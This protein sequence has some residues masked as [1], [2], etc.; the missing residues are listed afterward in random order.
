MSSSR[1]SNSR[2]IEI[3][4][5]EIGIRGWARWF[6]RQLTS[7]RTALLL[8]L[9]L[10]IAAV[11]GSIYPQRSA[12]P[13]GVKL[14][15]ENNPDLAAVLDNFQIFDVYTSVWF[16]AIYILLFTSLVGCVVP[17]TKVHYAALRSQPPV[18][19]R[20]FARMP[21]HKI[22]KSRKANVVERAA[23]ILR[24]Q[25]YRVVTTRTA[26]SAERGY[27]RETGNLI[28]HFSLIGV[29]ISVGIG[30]GLSYSGQRVLVEGDTF[31]NNL[32]GYDSIS[33]GTFFDESRLTPFS[34]RLDKF[35]VIFDIRN[36]TNIGTPLDFKATVTSQVG[37]AGEPAEGIIRVNEPLELPD[38]K[39]YLT[40]NGY[41]PV[42]TV[43]DASGEVSFSG[44][45][46]FLPQDKNYTSLGVYKLPDAKPKQFG[47]IA[48]F[49]PTAA[50]L[51]NGAKSSIFPDPINPLLTM[52][53]YVGDLGLDQGIP[54]N[55]Y[56]LDIA[57]MTQVAGG[58]AKSKAIELEKGQTATLPD[59][60]G[61][62]TFDSLKRFI[63]LDISYNP[64]VGWI[65]LFALLSLGGLMITLLVPRRRVWVRAT[66]DG[67]ELAALARGDDPTLEKVLNDLTEEI[68]KAKSE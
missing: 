29:L 35:S 61:T 32:A 40:G 8:L 48:F 17:R 24:K 44:P 3:E 54:R 21:A 30:G 7:M 64:G 57:E 42:I 6:W 36:K 60:L 39:L 4:S 14:Y 20:N 58:K 56:S 28:F 38:A 62:V 5:P 47:M 19:P 26:V 12:D 53:V 31:V 66:E 15:F 67:F 22:V 68:K 33:P 34:V 49:Y 25:G 43:R 52:N 23:K 63:S 51:K 37:A 46:A 45:V 10:A 41:A 2:D 50:D 27:L 9:L 1:P 55:V 59:G 13:N 18:A 11:P 16:S 65:L